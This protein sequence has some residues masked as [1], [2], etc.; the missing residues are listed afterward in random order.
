MV[1]TNTWES[2]LVHPNNEWGGSYLAS[3]VDMLRL[4]DGFRL[5]GLLVLPLV[6]VLRAVA[7][8]GPVDPFAD[9]QL[10]PAPVTL[11]EPEGFL[12]HNFTFKK[13]VFSQFSYGPTATMSDDSADTEGWYSR[14]SVG[15]E[16]FKKFS[17]AS[18][19]LGAL[20]LQG[21]IV[22]RDNYV[23]VID[24]EEGADREGW[25]FEYHNLYLD[26]YN[27]FNPLL[28]ESQRGPAT[29]HFNFRIGHFYVP[30]GLNLQTDTHGA[31]LQLSNDRNF[32]FERDWYGGFYGS[33]TPE[34]NYDLY[35]LLG[36][37]YDPTLLGQAGLV[38]ARVSLA[39]TL[40]NE[41]GIEGGLSFLGGQRRSDDTIDRSKAIAEEAIRGEFVS[42]ERIG[43]DARYSHLLAQGSITGTAE[44]SAGEDNPEHVFTQLYQ[45]DYLPQ[46]RRWGVATQFRRFHQS[47]SQS[48]PTRLNDADSSIIGELTW[49]FRNDIGNTNLHWVKLNVEQ[50]LERMSG[51]RST[52]TTLQYYRYW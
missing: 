28:D 26:L 5:I 27:V 44:L 43:I 38:G 17:D 21:R 14:Q 8:S 20:D 29:G 2:F 16:V 37:G 48:D 40:L 15:A 52:V 4:I 1:V 39:N 12:S 10:A 41:Y 49:Y 35:Y 6:V 47:F 33:I 42:T 34:L 23:A 25:Y 51:S 24:D 50:Q 45:V 11:G 46:S 36:S 22:R 13:E 19:T 31:V 7:D 30:F 18:S 3:K 9:L 32:G